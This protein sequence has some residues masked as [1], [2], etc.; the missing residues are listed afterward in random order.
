MNTF[1]K[2]FQLFRHQRVLRAALSTQLSILEEG[3]NFALGGLTEVEEEAVVLLVRKA[4]RY[5]GP[6]IEFGT[7]FGI[8]TKLMASVATSSQKVV[9][10]DNFCWNPF[11]LT[12]ELHEI[13]TRKILR[14]ELE[15]ER[16]ELIVSGS[17]EFRASYDGMVPALVFLDADHSYDA[18]KDEIKWAKALGVP[19]IAGNDYRNERFGVT[20][21]VDEEFPDGVEF[22]GMVWWKQA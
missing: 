12:P 10:V 20:R 7:L 4:Q 6:L 19:L 13:F 17:Q 9:T 11:G 21:A 16:V 2:L 5:P 14:F 8:T 22:R 18:V 3:E 1:T 15:S